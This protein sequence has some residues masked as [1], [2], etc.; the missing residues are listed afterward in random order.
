MCRQLVLLYLALI[1]VTNIEGHART[2]T[3]CQLSRELLRYNF[4]RALISNCKGF[5]NAEMDALAN[6]ELISKVPLSSLLP[7]RAMYVEL[8]LDFDLCAL[9]KELSS[10]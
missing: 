2:F 6:T 4:P 5:E 1:S 8:Y 7:R 3:R 10:L 9:L